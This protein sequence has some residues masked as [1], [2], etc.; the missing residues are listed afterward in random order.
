MPQI[1]DPRLAAIGQEELTVTP[2]HVALLAA[3]VG[4]EGVMP[5]AYLVV[6]TER[7][8]EQWQAASPPGPAVRVISAELANS[9]RAML[10]PVGDGGQVVGHGS[11]ALSGADLPPLA[12]FMGLA[13][14]Q[15]PRY[16]VVVLL[17]HDGGLALAER[18]GSSALVTALARTP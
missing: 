13:P 18:I 4:A 5:P 6:K 16:A 9:L 12:W 8:A 3:T 1:T 17:E 15:A 7:A 14:A 10:R 11:V 2:L